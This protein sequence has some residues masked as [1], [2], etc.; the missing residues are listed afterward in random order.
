MNSK[1][2]NQ[3]KKLYGEDFAH[4]CRSNFS[5]IL[6]EEGLL[7]ELI[8]QKIAP[9]HMI[10]KDLESQQSLNDFKFYINNAYYLL[11]GF[12]VAK[13][14]DS[15]EK[16]LEKAGYVLYPECTTEEEIRAFKKY[17]TKEEELCTFWGNR[18]K[19]CRVWFAVKKNVDEIKRENF[20]NPTR[21][22][23]YGTSVISIQF[24]RGSLNYLSIKNRYNHIVPNPDATFGNNLDNIIPGLTNAFE[25]TY[26]LKVGREKNI[27]FSLKN[28]C[29]DNSG[30]YHKLTAI[31]NWTYYCENNIVIR[32]GIPNYYNKDQYLLM[33][34]YLVDFKNKIITNL[35]GQSPDAFL[36]SIG[37]IE[38]IQVKNNNGVKTLV[39]NSKPQNSASDEPIEITV[40]HN[41]IVGYYNSKVTKIDDY[42]LENNAHVKSIDLPN[43]KQIGAYFLVCAR[44]LTALNLP[45]VEYIQCLFL[46]SN[47]ALK[48]VSLPELKKIGSDFLHDNTDLTKAYLPKVETIGE[49]FL[50]K[51]IKLKVLDLP[52]VE[53]IH[54]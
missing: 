28:Y 24:D 52:K 1:E 11:K 43:V 31:A 53:F 8:T 51:N 10:Y 47:T 20:T 5:T 27:T 21:Q 34:N 41:Q 3:I 42:F 38:S 7:L 16:L 18:L 46:A 30:R 13:S 22:D 19:I 50:Y 54:R 37:H 17:Y 36:E 12:P 48:S 25:K 45:K 2:L 40:D 15:P 6:E 9:T 49:R 35:N 14:E 32:D 33:D 23:D 4:F 39:I 26:N 44:N 29:K